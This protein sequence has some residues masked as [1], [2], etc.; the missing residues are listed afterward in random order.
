MK[1]NL[2]GVLLFT[3]IFSSAAFAHGSHFHSYHKL[4][5]HLDGHIARLEAMLAKGQATQA[6]IK[7]ERSQVLEH[8][9][10]YQSL[11]RTLIA[12]NRDVEVS[13]AIRALSAKLIRTAERQSLA[14]SLVVLKTM[15]RLLQPYGMRG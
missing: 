13:R 8:A 7:A 6:E 14:D 12:R 11:A 1:K 9:I 2:A 3:T 4:S 10:Q 15:K 5:A